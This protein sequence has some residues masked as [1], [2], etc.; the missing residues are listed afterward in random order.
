MNENRRMRRFILSKMDAKK[1]KAFIEKEKFSMEMT[2]IKAEMD[3]H[4]Q[5]V[6]KKNIP[7]IQRDIGLAFL[8]KWYFDIINRISL[9]IMALGWKW[10]AWA[11]QQLFTGPVQG[12]AKFIYSFG[13]KTIVNILENDLEMII[14]KRGKVIDRKVWNI[15]GISNFKIA[16]KGLKGLKNE[17]PGNY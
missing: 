6:I 11:F 16:M 12:F 1:R 13:T 17:K 3:S 7:E 15:P 9:A 2:R 4:W 14:Y 10:G 5:D 8:P